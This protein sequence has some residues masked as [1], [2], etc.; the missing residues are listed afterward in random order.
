ML[1]VDL[2]LLKRERRVSIDARIP[3]DHAM[4]LGLGARLEGPVEV[5]VEA[6]RA[7][8]DVVVRGRVGG[9]VTEGCRRCLRPVRAPFDDE[10]TW[11]YRAGVS[12]E[13]AEA[14]EVY[15]LARGRELDLAAAVRESVILVAPGY[16][17]CEE[18]CRGLCPTCGANRNETM[19]ECGAS[20]GDERWAVLRRLRSD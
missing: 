2:A 8:E 14:A 20:A 4:W 16:V 5:D 13:E 15:P 6:Q 11:L 9:I 10:V 3:P 17:L 18:G 19:C 1:K 12:E 7:G